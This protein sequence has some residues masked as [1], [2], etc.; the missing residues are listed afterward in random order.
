MGC[1]GSKHSAA[2][3]GI[4][5]P[6]THTTLTGVA[7]QHSVSAAT[8]NPPTFPSASSSLIA[9][10]NNN[11][12]NSDTTSTLRQTAQI[13][14]KDTATRT[15]LARSLTEG[16]AELPALSSSSMPESRGMQEISYFLKAFNALIK[17]F[18]ELKIDPNLQLS[19]LVAS[20]SDGEGLESYHIRKP[21][22]TVSTNKVSADFRHERLNHE[23]GKINNLGSRLDPNTHAYS[24][25]CKMSRTLANELRGYQSADRV[26]LPSNNND[27]FVI[28]AQDSNTSETMGAI[29]LKIWTDPQ[30]QQT[31]CIFVE[32]LISSQ[33]TK[34]IGKF[35]MLSA[36][37]LAHQQSAGNESPCPVALDALPSS[38][39]FYTRVGLTASEIIPVKGMTLI[40]CSTSEKSMPDIIENF[41]SQPMPSR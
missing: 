16:L 22:G 14:P 3:A 29:S 7:G 2:G 35:L 37:G 19:P 34:G 40:A 12:I 10:P 9:Q 28:L 27:S 33:S 26:P 1:I 6:S 32:H 39:P 17:K 13:H 41:F 38:V 11:K 5:Q 25:F 4:T 24:D 21:D 20:S 31:R 8:S 18:P 30:S 23:I 15:A 36:L